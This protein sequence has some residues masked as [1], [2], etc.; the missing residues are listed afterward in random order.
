[1]T[2]GSDIV[3]I[4]ARR[5][6]AVA[7]QA[8]LHDWM[9]QGLVTPVAVVD[10]DSLVAGQQAVPATVLADG[11]ATTTALQQRFAASRV[12]RVR[13]AVVNVVDEPDSVVDAAQAGQVLGVVRQSVPDVPVLQAC[14]N[15]GSPGAQWAARTLTVYGWHNLAVSPEESLAPAR[16]AAELAQS[17][18][19]PRW[20]LHLVGT[21]CSLTA[22]WPGQERSP[23]DD[24]AAP[25]GGLV[26]PVRAFSRS[27]SSGSV[28]DALAARLVSV[29]D[30]YPTPRVDSAYAV[31]AD[32]EASTAVGMA[33]QLLSVHMDV[34]P[35]VR[36][37]T[38]QEPARRIGAWEAIRGFLTFAGQSLVSAPGRAI[39]ALNRSVSQAA[40][41]AVQNAVFGGADSG[42]AVVV[43]G[44]RADGSSATW[45]EYEQ[46]LDSVIRRVAPNSGELAPVP[47]KPKLWDDFVAGGLTLLD[48]G[49]RSTDM[50]P[51]T[52]GSQRAVVSS[53]DR[54]AVDPADTFVLPPNVA[55]FLPNWEI[56]AG[57]DIAVGRL[58]ERL[59]HLGQS[60]P[61][62]AQ[63][64]GAEANR[65]R[66]WANRVRDSYA[67]HL[68]RTLGDA[69][70]GTILEVQQLTAA[71]ERLS[72]QPALPAGM[73]EEQ[74]SLAS[75]VRV[76]TAVS[77]SLIGIVIALTALSVVT[78]P[79]LI[80]AILAVVGGWAGTG[81]WLHV[82][83]SAR[84]YA[85]LHQARAATTQLEDAVRHR[86]EA[87]EDLRRI[88]RAYRQY[89]DW[90]RVLG[91]FI[92]APLGTPTASAERSLHVGQGL[93]LNL[94]I[95]VAVPDKE[96]V[97]DVAQRWRGELFRV[98]WL[99]EAWGEFRSDLPAALGPLRHALQTDPSLLSSDPSHDG[100]P[101]LTTW[102]R[103][104][105]AAAPTRPVS[106]ATAARIVDLTRADA[107][108]RDRL[109]GRV[110]VRDTQGAPR[111]LSRTQFIE[112]LERTGVQG[113]F[114]GGMF[115]P[116][117]AVVDIRDVRDTRSRED[118]T[119]LDVALV[120]AQFGGAYDASLLAGGRRAA[121]QPQTLQSSTDSFI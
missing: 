104:L 86:V 119:G 67:G 9:V 7:L 96:S 42:F 90:A 35:R 30:R 27:L 108:A 97:D 44:V 95:G 113:S 77:A 52:L 11:L 94:A 5:P 75:Q 17:S 21:L 18:S 85:I 84:T 117:G 99:S 10:L 29:R 38:P 53:T 31:S 55:A 60:Q 43:R 102:S 45:A 83:S 48:A 111:E 71:V 88:S 101:V 79:W 109:L 24:V 61:H 64:A 47:Q 115:D 12:A 116:A 37:A 4:A 20:L 59:E 112:G 110:L 114:Q 32:D 25:S 89:L 19:D 13:L 106:E 63:V 1:M 73:G 70:R 28:Q 92:H 8:V 57:D 3:V 107:E 46:S 36:H 6:V 22:L 121:D 65:L 26:V 58:F 15:A 54:V 68:G 56:Q 81:A 14:I 50:P 100:E 62:L 74:D 80:L 105:A 93:P 120:V 98:G 41:S 78:W 87:L 16:G 34:M 103:A 40:A 49:N 2:S 118:A 33:Q 91:A 82:R 72:A 69:H 23:L 51:R 76:M 39:E 66:E